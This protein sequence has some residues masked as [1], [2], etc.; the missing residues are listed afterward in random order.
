[1]IKGN[2]GRQTETAG[3]MPYA[4]GLLQ[5]K[6][7]CG[8]HTM[9]GGGCAECAKK[10]S[11]LQRKLAIGSDNDPLEQEADR[12]ADHVMASPVQA[13]GGEGLRIQR[14]TGQSHGPSGEA[15][16][17]VERVL[18]RPG[19]PLTR[20]LRQ[21]M[22]HRFG[23]DFSRV[24]V[25]S[26]EAAGQSAREVNA[27]AYTVG[28]NVV[29]GRGRFVP[30]SQEGRRLLAHELT[31]V[32]QQGGTRPKGAASHGSVIRSS[33][34]M[35]QRRME[36]NPAAITPLPPGA[37]GPPTP[38]TVSV[39]NLLDDT[40]PSG[41]ARVNTTTGVVTMG[42][43]VC[44]WAGIPYRD[45]VRRADI[46]ATPAGCGCLCDV[47]SHARTTTIDFRAGGP[48]TS[49]GSVAGAGAGQGGVQ[50]DATVSIDPRFQ[51]QY[52]I[53][54]RWVDVP[55]HL[56]FSHE[57]CGHALPKMQGTHV[58]RGAGP[59]GGTPPQERRAVDVE[60]EIAAEG[61]HPRRPEDYSGAARQRP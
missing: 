29:F 59:R 8:T 51:G 3:S 9:A 30:E 6:C 60:R 58:A 15:P 28:P 25:H 48:G 18:T 31:H 45:D 61:G 41:G 56:L 34:P 2:V 24:R 54:G 40:C 5:R 27:Q 10:N 21:D 53:G 46:S 57:V 7:A 4:Q 39:Q 36:V 16:A 38:L 32:V 14:Y 19:E 1:M 42:A 20:S 11:A 23:H 35:V 22:E 43:G 47:V 26:D 33:T 49:P 50:T 44:D 17:S 55:F 12:I 13:S 52:R 37:L